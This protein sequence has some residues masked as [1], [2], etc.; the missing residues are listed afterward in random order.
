MVT[1]EDDDGMSVDHLDNSTVAE[2]TYKDLQSLP[3]RQVRFPFG[4]PPR[5]VY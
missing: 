3:T 5:H 2:M 4:T 1:E